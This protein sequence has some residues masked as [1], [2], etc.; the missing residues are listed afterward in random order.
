M[1]DDGCSSRQ[2]VDQC[3][4]VERSSSTIEGSP[5]AFTPK[6]SFWIAKKSGT[7][8]FFRRDSSTGTRRATTRPRLVTSTDSPSSIQRNTRGKWFLKSA[9]DNGVINHQADGSGDTA[10]RRSR[11]HERYLSHGL[12]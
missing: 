2:M 5:P 4:Y 8:S 9:T 12:L 3:R 7:R 6:I 10:K 1:V 11:L